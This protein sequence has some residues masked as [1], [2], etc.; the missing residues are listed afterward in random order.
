VCGSAWQSQRTN[1]EARADGD[2]ASEA[3]EW[4]W[5]QRAARDA[6][7]PASATSSAPRGGCERIS[8]SKSAGWGPRHGPPQRCSA[9]APVL[10]DL[11]AD[12]EWPRRLDQPV[13]RWH[14]RTV[15]PTGE[16]EQQ[17]SAAAC[18]PW[19]ALSR[20][21]VHLCAP[22]R[23]QGPV[24]ST[25]R[26]MSMG[27]VQY[28]R[29]VPSAMV[30]HMA[31]LTCTDVTAARSSLPELQTRAVEHH[32]P[33][34][35]RRGDADASVLLA[36]SDL[37][38]SFSAFR[39]E[40]H[41]SVSDGEATA[42]LDSLG[43]LGLGETADEAVED[44]ALELR[45]FAQRYFEKAAFYRETP[46]RGYLPWLLRFAATPEDRQ[47]DLLYEEPA[48]LPSVPASTSVLR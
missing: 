17:R 31:A 34:M 48:A 35:S 41:V 25:L 26:R 6:R 47:L 22:K 8:R 21:R 38:S 7:S 11:H 36:A 13:T 43:I 10:L 30:T 15:S 1:A 44:L 12:A 46:L 40:P 27:T 3:R 37:A 23:D 45:R 39:F 2:R 16:T 24:R 18:R 32:R 20:R 29:L 19:L 4:V 9:T 14:P 33:Q 42:R 28:V 5:S